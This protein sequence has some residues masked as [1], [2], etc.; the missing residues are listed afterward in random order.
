M[1]NEI[2]ITESKLTHLT[3]KCEESLITEILNSLSIVKSEMTNFWDV[4]D[5]ISPNIAPN[6]DL[7]DKVQVICLFSIDGNVLFASRLYQSPTQ[8]WVKLHQLQIIKDNELRFLQT[9]WDGYDGFITR[10]NL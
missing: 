9:H 2:I 10:A 3:I 5:F 6:I 8:F 1:N 7:I 4:S